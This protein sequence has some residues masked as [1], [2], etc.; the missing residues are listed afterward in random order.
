MQLATTLNWKQLVLALTIC[1]FG[2]TGN[3]FSNTA[4]ASEPVVRLVINYGDGF[5]KHYTRIEFQDGMTVHDAMNQAAAHP[6]GVKFE[7]RGAGTTA[8]LESIDGLKF[9][10][11]IN[12][13]GWIF[14]IN[15]KVSPRGMG[16]AE[17]KA[18]DTVLWRHEKFR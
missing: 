9:Q 3:L 17:L 10:R 11:G 13:R 14:R 5:E 2:A 7:H 1:V 6:R 18:G 16:V 4:R 15:G 8:Y 12:G